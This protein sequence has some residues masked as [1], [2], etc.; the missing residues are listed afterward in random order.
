MYHLIG[1]NHFR[2]DAQPRFQTV[3]ISRINTTDEIRVFDIFSLITHETPLKFDAK[4]AFF[5]G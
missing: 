1:D 5:I 2:S 3:Y 4:I